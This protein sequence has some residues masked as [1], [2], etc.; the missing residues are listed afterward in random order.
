M[1]FDN[2]QNWCLDFGVFECILTCA[3][4]GC[5]TRKSDILKKQLKLVHK[6]VL[7]C[8]VPCST[9][10]NI[11]KWPVPVCEL[12][13]V[14]SWFFV[15]KWKIFPKYLTVISKRMS[16]QFFTWIN[17]DYLLFKKYCNS[18]MPTPDAFHKFKQDVSEHSERYLS[19]LG[20][21]KPCWETETD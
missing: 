15:H 11:I 12:S 3:T 10:I 7:V 6:V 2:M 1:H 20:V 16:M 18:I 19:R 21:S 4:F 5:R 13:S 9:S 17:S 14:E 8:S